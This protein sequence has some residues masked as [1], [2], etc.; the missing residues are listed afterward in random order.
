[1]QEKKL[2][3]D[4]FTFFVWP[5]LRKN[6]RIPQSNIRITFMIYFSSFSFALI[7]LMLLF[8]KKGLLRE[9]NSCFSKKTKYNNTT[10][11]VDKISFFGYLNFYNP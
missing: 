4:I 1:M 8:Y 10:K 6:H 7:C 9:L 11:L 5:L 2:T 3:K